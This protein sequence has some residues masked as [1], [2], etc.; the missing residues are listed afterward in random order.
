MKSLLIILLV[1]FNSC[2]PNITYSVIGIVLEIDRANNKML[3]DHERIK[4]FMEPMIMNFNT[5]DSVDLNQ[6]SELD[7]VTFD[8]VITE[9]SHYS[10]NYKI[11]GK[12]TDSSVKNNIFKSDDIYSQINV[13]DKISD[14]SFTKTNNDIYR[15]LGSDS[16]LKVISFIFSRCPIPEMCPATIIKKQSIAKSFTD[17]KNVE[18]IFISFDYKYDTPK[19]IRDKYAVIENNYENMYFLSSVDH[20]N[21][22]FL[23]TKQSGISFGGVEDNNIG[24]TMRT[25]IVDNNLT[26]LKFYEGINWKPGDVK[27]DIRSF[28][29]LIDK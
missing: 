19:I 20:I 29:N 18:F 28:L 14:V 26:L 12:R 2:K 9:D 6:F 10:L 5:H 22:L 25:I 24:H 3:I 7:S 23:I 21:D 13:G 17:N 16:K 1:L 27:I 4:G 15:L 8:I 11:L